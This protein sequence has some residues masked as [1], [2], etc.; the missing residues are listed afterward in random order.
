MFKLK[1]ETIGTIFI[2]LGNILYGAFI[3]I[4]NQTTKQIQPLFFASISVLIAS[5][6][7]LVY[8]FYKGKLK[9]LKIRKS[10]Y[11]ILMTTLF[12]VIIPFTLF[13]IGASKTS[14][15]NSSLLLL[16]EIIFTVIITPF[17]GETTSLYKILGAGGIFL[18][19]IFILYN[20]N[21][22]INIGDI[23]IILSTLT[24]PLGNFYAKK[25]LN[26]VSS[27]II[28][29]IRFLL[30]GLVIGTLSLMFEPTNLIKNSIVNHWPII[31]LNGIL[32]LSVSKMFY[33]EALK[34]M[35]ISKTISLGM[36]FPIY[37]LL[38]LT[39]FFKEEITPYKWIGIAVML[40]GV[41]FTIKRKSVDPKLTKYAH[42]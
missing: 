28:L 16:S 33:Y 3:V 34:R 15:I 27:E 17:F 8:A 14:G 6:T 31:L 32:L 23:L 22:K 11:P 29:F 36:T 25:A 12:I 37:S 20:N 41:Y 18:G 35:D 2:L 38:I 10:Y 26:L 21:F 24:F 19:A 42:N 1:P 30:G 5:L 13:F 4:V 40:I 9:E 39:I 7:T